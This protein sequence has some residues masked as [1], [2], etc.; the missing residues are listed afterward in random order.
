MEKIIK[1]GEHEVRLNNNVA[2]TMEYKTQ[3]GR[4]ILPSIM[5]LVA[6][7]IESVT[8][9]LNESGR[10]DG[11]PLQIRDIT[12]A[13]E[14]RAMDLLLPLFQLEFTDTVINVLW[15]M[16]KAADESIAPPKMWVKQFEEFP[17]DIIIPAIGELVVS[18]FVSSKNRERLR[19]IGANLKNLQPSH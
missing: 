5:P 6:S 15:S 7:G 4:D 14:G 13:I 1:I 8:A 12:E 11:E 18:G 3:F 17:L 10:K 16:A 2:W 9:I 19:T